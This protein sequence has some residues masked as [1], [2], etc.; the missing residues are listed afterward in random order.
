MKKLILLSILFI[1]GCEDSSVNSIQ[2]P[3][4]FID[5]IDF[6]SVQLFD[7]T[8]NPN[9]EMNGK[10]SLSY[11]NGDEIIYGKKDFKNPSLI[12]KR[13]ENL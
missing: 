1:V 3:Y 13:G 12:I 9:F 10:N 11:C 5:N 8:G 6:Q 4:P 2:K 7:M